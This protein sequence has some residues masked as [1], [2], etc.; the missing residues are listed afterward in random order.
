MMESSRYNFIQRNTI[1]IWLLIFI[2]L[3]ISK[4]VFKN[5]VITI[6]IFI[7]LLIIHEILWYK[8][9]IQV[10]KDEGEVTNNFID[11]LIYT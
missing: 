8:A 6:H 1:G 11:G 5:Y 4:Y 7:I 3:S 2:S 9:Y 10:T